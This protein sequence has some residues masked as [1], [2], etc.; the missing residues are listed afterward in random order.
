VIPVE[1]REAIG[2]LV[3]GC[4]IC[5]D[6]CPWNV[7]FSRDLRVDAFRAH[8]LFVDADARTLAREVLKMTPATYAATLRGS[9]MK[10]AKLWMLKR[11][12][13]VV[14]GNIGTREDHAMLGD[15]LAHE[16]AIVREHAAWALA[17]L[18]SS[19]GTPAL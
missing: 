7:S 14:L 9:A 18:G 19:L 3:Y 6:V 10:R 16:H 8:E 1:F 4:D 15:M 12:A 17:Q 13:C 5:Q 2:E 11:N